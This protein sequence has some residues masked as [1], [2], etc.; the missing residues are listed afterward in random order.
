MNTIQIS[1]WL[2]VVTLSCLAF[3][4]IVAESPAADEPK[5]QKPVPIQW[6]TDYNQAR[7]EAEAKKLPLVIV[8]YRPDNPPSIY[9]FRKWENL[10]AL[11]I[12]LSEN[13]I[14]LKLDGKIET[15]LRTA[16]NIAVFPTTIIARPD[17]KIVETLVG[18]HEPEKL[19]EAVKKATRK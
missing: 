17:G 3:F 18:L 11:A 2:T 15:Y 5:E 9:V 13:A 12:Y 7:K 4:L 6:R 1:R 16:L 10:R 14:P 8:F 19:L